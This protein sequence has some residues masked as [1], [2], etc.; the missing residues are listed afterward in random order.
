MR[1]SNLVFKVDLQIKSFACM[2][3][4]MGK[5]AKHKALNK[6]WKL[7]SHPHLVHMEAVEF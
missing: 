1:A 7:Y 2:K 5:K 3:W 6:V 4:W